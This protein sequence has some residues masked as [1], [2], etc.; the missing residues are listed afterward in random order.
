MTSGVESHAEHISRGPVGAP[1]LA[2]TKIY[3]GAFLKVFK[4]WS[5]TY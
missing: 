2:I 1:H 5:K 4:E 3:L